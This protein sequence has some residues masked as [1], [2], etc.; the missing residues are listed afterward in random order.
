MGE[1]YVCTK[2]NKGRKIVEHHITTY[3]SSIMGE[4]SYYT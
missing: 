3:K 2:M 1:I 4:S